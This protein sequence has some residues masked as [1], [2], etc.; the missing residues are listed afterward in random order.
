MKYSALQITLQVR[1][2]LQ[3]EFSMYNKAKEKQKR[4]EDLPNFQRRSSLQNTESQMMVAYPHKYEVAS[5]MQC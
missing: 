3:H 2:T 4:N 5:Q 1:A